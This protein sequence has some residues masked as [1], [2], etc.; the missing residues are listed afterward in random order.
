MVN[1]ELSGALFRRSFYLGNIIG[2][3][4]HLNFER[5]N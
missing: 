4:L 2:L 3:K 1:G 5:I